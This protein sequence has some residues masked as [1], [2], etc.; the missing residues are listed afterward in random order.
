MRLNEFIVDMMTE[1]EFQH[2][3][4]FDDC[5]HFMATILR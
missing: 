5:E 3:I 2:F 1:Y 4:C